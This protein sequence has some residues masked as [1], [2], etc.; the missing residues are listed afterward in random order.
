MAADKPLSVQQ[1]LVLASP[2]VRLLGVDA[3]G[4]P[5]VEAPVG[6]PQQVRRWAVL[7][8]GDPADV[9]EPVRNVCPGG[10]GPWGTAVGGGGRPVCPVCQRG[11]YG[12]GVGRPTRQ[13]G[14][15]PW[16]GQVPPHLS[17]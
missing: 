14:S 6:I 13:Q 4:R 5:V 12:L 8:S 1:R 16:L 17:V 9:T 7:R 11:P 3:K 2:R 15:G 10:G